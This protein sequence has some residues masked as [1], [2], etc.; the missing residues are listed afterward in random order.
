MTFKTLLQR[1]LQEYRTSLLLTPLLVAAGLSMVV[2]LGVLLS[3]RFSVMGQSVAELI[4]QSES[5]TPTNISIHIDEAEGEPT[6]EYRVERELGPLA[7]GDSVSKSSSIPGAAASAGSSSGSLNPLLD[8]VHTLF[9]LVLILVVAN[10]L[11]ATLYS[12]RR[13][14]SILFWK[15][16]PVSEW[17]GVLAKF[18]VALLVV[19]TVFYAASLL[20][21]AV[22]ILLAMLLA[23][24]MELEPFAL[25][26][27]NLDFPKLLMGQLGGWLLMSLWIA[28]TYA[29][30]LLA[31]AAARRS[32]F[33]TAAAPLVGLVV[34]EKII[35]GSATLGAVISRHMP[36]YG[37]GSSTGFYWLGWQD[38]PQ[39]ALGLV[40][41]G[42]AL[43]VAVYLRRYRFEN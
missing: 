26:L 42:L 11:L 21:Q 36:H 7:P 6:F 38:L 3:N 31:S 1:E 33:M 13:D 4:Q 24:R 28:P 12:D 5:G 16:M 9:L 27:G 22:C 25:I 14:N 30:L 18:S 32:P 23:W 43:W 20:S 10:Y 37:D 19:P 39:M 15:S 41:T 40:F 17:Q 29:W 35:L 8:G 2:L 34:L